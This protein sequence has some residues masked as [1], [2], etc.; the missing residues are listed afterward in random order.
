MR[1]YHLSLWIIPFIFLHCNAKK[2][3]YVTPGEFGN[4]FAIND[5]LLSRDDCLKP[6]YELRKA[7]R[8]F[9]YELQQ[10][11]S[12]KNLKNFEYLIVFDQLPSHEH[13]FLAE[14]PLKKRILFLWEPPTVKPENYRQ[15][16]HEYFSKVFTWNDDLIDNK[17]YFKFYYPQPSL[18]M[19]SSLP[20]SQKK[21]SVMIAKNK[22]SHHPAQLYA[23]RQ[24]VIS[25]FEQYDPKQFDLYGYWWNK[26]LK[27]YKNPV[28]RKS[29]CL[30][31]Y[32]FCFCFENIKN[33]NGY[34]TEKIFDCFIAECIP[35]YWGARNIQQYV[36][37]SCFID[38][39]NFSSLQSLITFLQNM[40]EETYNQILCNISSFLQSPQAHNFSTEY[41]VNLWTHYFLRKS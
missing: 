19:N 27:T 36:P 30:K 20:F 13:A 40:P 15:S 6:L 34:V 28:L 18:T 2:T 14:Y 22:W 16:Y 23:Q 1:L 37:T 8:K 12:I 26:N 35:V 25:F 29:D 39:R 5:P 9:D 31:N 21:L 11:N 41:F 17:R 38:I 7:A 32:K 3:I 24:A 10:I 33:L 4:L